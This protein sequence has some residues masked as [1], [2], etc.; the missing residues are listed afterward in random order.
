M[1]EMMDAVREL[2]ARAKAG[3]GD[4][5]RDEIGRLQ[6][7]IQ[8]WTDE[9]AAV[10]S[11][12]YEGKA[13]GDQVVA[14]VDGH[15]GLMRLEIGPYAMRDLDAGELGQACTAAISAARITLSEALLA[16][17]ATEKAESAGSVEPGRTEPADP[18]EI[19]RQ[20]KEA[21]GWNA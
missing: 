20:A 2:T 21:A 16:H 5:V 17:V 14:E 11:G 12:S 6:D 19:W 13:A 18:R 8:S 15:G 10:Q 9:L 4:D 1:S 7:R 3:N